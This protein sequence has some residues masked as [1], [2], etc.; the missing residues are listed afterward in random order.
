MVSG[1]VLDIDLDTGSQEESTGNFKKKSF[2][3]K[4]RENITKR[5]IMNEIRQK[6]GD[7]ITILLKELLII[8]VPSISCLFAAS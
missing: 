1:I 3:N 8:I 7:C 4:K 2:Q 6:V 5:N